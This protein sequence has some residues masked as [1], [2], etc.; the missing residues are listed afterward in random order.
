[1]E[2]CEITL[3]VSDASSYQRLVAEFNKRYPTCHIELKDDYDRT[4]LLT[5]L[6]A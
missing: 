4:A 3:A 5:E 1:M 6:T 2:L